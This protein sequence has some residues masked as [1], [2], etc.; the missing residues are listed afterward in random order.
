MDEVSE[1]WARQ[2][3]LFFA[4][5]STSILW[6]L[7][8]RP[9]FSAH[10]RAV[11]QIIDQILAER[12]EPRLQNER[13]KLVT[14]IK[15]KPEPPSQDDLDFWDVMDEEYES[16]MRLFEEPEDTPGSTDKGRPAAPEAEFWLN[17][18]LSAPLAED[19]AYFDPVPS[20]E[21][22]PRFAESV[23]ALI[24]G[25]VSSPIFHTKMRLAEKFDGLDPHRKQQALRWTEDYQHGN[26]PP[27]RR[28]RMQEAYIFDRVLERSGILNALPANA[29]RDKSR[30]NY[31]TMFYE[32][33]PEERKKLLHDAGVDQGS[34]LNPDKCRDV[35]IS[36][37]LGAAIRKKA[38][39]QQAVVKP[40]PPASWQK[41]SSVTLAPKT[42]PAAPD[43]DRQLSGAKLLRDFVQEQ[44]R[45]YRRRAAHSPQLKT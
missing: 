28:E 40:R 24:P 29:D 3:S 35:I 25:G 36:L 12:E 43:L 18:F 9:S 33:A 38:A 26:I 22:V 42:T 20:D 39:V 14:Q 1:E 19:S 16:N 30:G 32:L 8:R 2:Q 37:I 21:L 45:A 41:R 23:N 34:G 27:E 4:G 44:N 6:E 10:N 5:L 13:I 31:A 17:Q 15:H 11:D 7:R